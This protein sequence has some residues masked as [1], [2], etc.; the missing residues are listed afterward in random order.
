MFKA[1][2]K[3][4]RQK[5]DK[6]PVEHLSPLVNLGSSTGA[7]RTKEQF[8]T[9]EEL[10][11]PLRARGVQLVHVDRRE[12]D[13]GI[14]IRA[15]LMEDSG[16]AQ[17]KA[18]R[19]RAALCCNILEHVLDPA[20]LARR[21]MDVLQPGGYLFVTVPYSYPYHRDPIDTMFRPTPDQVAALLPH[22][23]MTTGEILDVDESYLGEIRK[24][25]WIIL[26][27]VIRFPFPFVSP[28]RWKRSMRKLYW[29]ANN[30][31]VT[32]AIFRKGQA[33]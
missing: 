27:H 13:D 22:E 3:W 1:E 15:D 24:R 26:R 25:P 21:C 17:V 31:Q 7:F 19:P 30:Y 10:F 2:A 11:A 4:L 14:D 32:C 28:H 20:A 33:A 5:L 16:L 6:L 29:L 18:V 23:A 12:E 8:W 9:E